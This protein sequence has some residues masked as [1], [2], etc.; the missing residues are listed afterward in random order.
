MPHYLDGLGT[1]QAFN[2][3]TV[4]GSLGVDPGPVAGFDIGSDGIAWLSAGNGLYSVNLQTGAATA[5]GTIDAPGAPAVRS[6]AS[7]VTVVP[8]PEASVYSVLLLT[9]LATMGRRRRK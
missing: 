3:V 2:T 5:V 9:G 6:I 8:V 1:V 4:V 7:A